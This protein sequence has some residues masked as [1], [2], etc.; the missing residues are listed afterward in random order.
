MAVSNNLEKT[1]TPL[2]EEYGTA[3]GS[4]TK[5]GAETPVTAKREIFFPSA[6]EPFFG[7]GPDD[8]KMMESD[9][10]WTGVCPACAARFETGD[11]WDEDWED[12]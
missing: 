1:K 11:V 12:H 3:F 7:D 10:P 2:F 5:C 4:C 9:S 6:P 8:D